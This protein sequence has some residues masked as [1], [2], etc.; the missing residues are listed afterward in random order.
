[1]DAEPLSVGVERGEPRRAADVAQP[2]PRLD[3]PRH[4]GNGRVRDAQKN[5]LATFDPQLD[6]ALAQATGDCRAG[7]A[8]GA[9]DGDGV[10]H[11][12]SSSVADTGH[13]DCIPDG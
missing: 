2:G 4:V 8:A 3:R 10:E 13:G 6:A 11:S 9:D 12:C 5:E 7:S 1:M